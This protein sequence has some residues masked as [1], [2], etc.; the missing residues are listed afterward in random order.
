MGIKQTKREIQQ[1]KDQL[2]AT[3]KAND[4]QLLKMALILVV[5]AIIAG[6]VYGRIQIW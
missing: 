1:L 6:I 4:S 5:L 2:K 3:K